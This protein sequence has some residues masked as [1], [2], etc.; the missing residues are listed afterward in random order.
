MLPHDRHG[1]SSTQRYTPPLPGPQN[2]LYL[3]PANEGSYGRSPPRYEYDGREHWGHGPSG[4]RLGS[5]MAYDVNALQSHAGGRLPPPP[6]PL[7][8]SRSAPS[9]LPERTTAT[10]PSTYPPLSS[11]FSA[12]NS[13]YS[14][15]DVPRYTPYPLPTP[16]LDSGSYNPPLSSPRRPEPQHHQPKQPSAAAEAVP[17]RVSYPEWNTPPPG[18]YPPDTTPGP[19][20]ISNYGQTPAIRPFPAKLNFMLRNPGVYGDVI[21]WDD[22]GTIVLVA[23]QS[24]RFTAE[25]LP[26][27]FSHS[28]VPAFNRQLNI[29]GFTHLATADIGHKVRA[30]ALSVGARLGDAAGWSHPHFTE[31]TPDDLHMLVPKPSKARRLLQSAKQEK[32]DEQIRSGG[33]PVG[34]GNDD[35]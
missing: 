1:A 15:P 21:A 25:V 28:S 29:Y 10:Y 18:D 7:L 24:Q 35:E 19:P 8:H 27:F 34:P 32:I 30:S 12:S 20:T 33:G 4:S 23:H 22:T 16:Y 3:P 5:G 14:Y 6:P 26:L 31:A 2:G 17:R 11:S 9:S 13:P